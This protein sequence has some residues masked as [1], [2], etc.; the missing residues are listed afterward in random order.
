M[1]LFVDGPVST[2]DDLTHQDSGLLDVAETCGIDATTK[3]WLAHEELETDLQLW[4]DR[5]R[6]TL[7]LVFGPVLRMEQ[8]VVTPALKRWGIMQ[9]LSMFYRDAYFSQLVDRYQARWDEYSRLTRDAYERFVASGLGLVMS[10]V[11]KAAIPA[12]S[13]VAGPQQGGTFYASVSW[14]NT[15]GQEGAASEAAS[16]TVADNNLMTVSAVNA[17]AS[18]AGFNVYAGSSL[19]GIVVQNNVLLAPGASFTYVPGFTTHGRGPGLG[20]RPD[21]VRPLARTLLRG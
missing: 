10:P 21:V 8:V 3:L 6:P 7:E 4:L 11:R 13:T 14:V 5:P 17:P 9:A 19:N 20:Q 1:A 2:I 12:L 18:A 16:V 15:A